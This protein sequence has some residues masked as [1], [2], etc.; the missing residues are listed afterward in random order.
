MKPEKRNLIHDLLDEQ[1]DA[2]RE[3]TLLAGG[4]VL[5]ARRWRRRAG[6]I[7]ATV[8]VLGLAAISLHRW[9]T[10]RPVAVNIAVAPSVPEQAQPAVKSLT[11]AELLAM[12]P[13]TPVV[14]ATL[15]NGQKKLIFPRSGD[16]QRFVGRL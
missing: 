13:D 9:L 4:R 16:E 8:T 3:A 14:L 15:G 12:F 5:R 6:Q 7:F 11:D 1:R 2:R 10:P